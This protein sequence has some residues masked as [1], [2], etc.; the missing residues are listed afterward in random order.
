MTATTIR[1]Y[2]VAPDRVAKGTPDPFN[3]GRIQVVCTFDPETFAQIRA[4][5]VA[6]RTSFIEQVRLLVEWG[7]EAEQNAEKMS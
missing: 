1:N 2:R 6:E 4:R 5:A 3:P 7:L